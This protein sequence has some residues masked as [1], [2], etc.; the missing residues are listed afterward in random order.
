MCRWLGYVG[1]PIRPAELLYEPERSLIEQSRRHAP[2][3]AVP[4][5][6]GTGLGWYGR[7]PVPALFRSADPAWGEANLHELATEIESGL[8]L[9]HV[10]AATGTPVQESNC[11]PFRFGRWLFVHNGYIAEFERLRRDLLFAVNPEIFGNIRGLDG[12]RADVPSGSHVR[13][14]AGSDRCLGADGRVRG[15]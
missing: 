14:R 8:F 7:R 12:L 5:G 10:R 6:D 11:H 15:D 4:N 13:S 1:S 9:A 2:D 3:M